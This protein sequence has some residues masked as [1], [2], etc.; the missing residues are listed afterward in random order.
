MDASLQAYPD[1][2]DP[3][4]AKTVVIATGRNWPDA[5]GGAALAGVLDGPILLVPTNSVPESVMAEIG[6][7]G[8]EKAIILGGR[9]AVGDGVLNALTQELGGGNVRRI[10]GGDRYET[11]SMIASEVIAAAGT[12]YDG[13]AFVATGRNFPDALAAAPLAAGNAWPIFLAHP[14]S[15]LMPG[16]RAA[17]GDVRR[18]LVLGGYGAVLPQTEAYL[19]TVYGDDNVTRLSGE[20]RYQ[21]AISIAT[22][23]VDEAGMQ[24]DKVALA[25][26]QGFADALSGGV[27]QGKDRS[28]LL[29]TPPKA[30]DPGV[31]ATLTAKKTLIRELRYL[32]GPSA[33]SFAVRTQV[34]HALK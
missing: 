28:V 1:G 33:V 34:T 24:W 18:V 14:T 29:L 12:D 17:M 2:L 6:R 31:A 5:L 32:G 19:E 15:G 4:G 7:L 30:L 16:T 26:G 25:T 11:A 21:T 20:T 9:S 10:D 23:G 22:Y 27:V 8:A 3:D 13:T